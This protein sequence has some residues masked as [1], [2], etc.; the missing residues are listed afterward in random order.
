MFCIKHAK[1]PFMI[2]VDTRGIGGTWFF[3]F[4][5]RPRPHYIMP[6]RGGEGYY[7]ILVM[8]RV[9]VDNGWPLT[10][11]RQT[12][13]AKDIFRRPVYT[14]LRRDWCSFPITSDYFLSVS[15]D[16]LMSDLWAF[17]GVANWPF[18]FFSPLPLILLHGR[19]IYRGSLMM[20]M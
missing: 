4:I 12:F 10:E 3:S 6:T 13:S 8:F 20:K 19:S 18:L 15:V 5:C 9:H 16:N 17:H 2:H 1:G 7:P 11:L 14:L